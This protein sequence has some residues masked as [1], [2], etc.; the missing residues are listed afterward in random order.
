[1]RR[2]G[3]AASGVGEARDDQHCARGMGR[4]VLQGHV[5]GVQGEV[6]QRVDET[7]EGRAKTGRRIAVAAELSKPVRLS[8]ASTQ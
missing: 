8:R 5:L 6:R 4:G 3:A 1:M 7:A 2:I